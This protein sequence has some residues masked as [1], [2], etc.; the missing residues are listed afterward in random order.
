MRRRSASRKQID[1]VL[2]AF[3]RSFI[4]NSS[5]ATRNMSTAIEYEID[6][7]IFDSSVQVKSSVLIAIR[8]D[9]LVFVL[10]THQ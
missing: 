8:V 2:T 6:L 7:P 1:V 5:T 3:G 4:Y 10:Y 9:G